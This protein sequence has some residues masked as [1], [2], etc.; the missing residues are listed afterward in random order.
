MRKKG[1]AARIQKA[2]RLYDLPAR[3]EP[4]GAGER[5]ISF[6]HAI[7]PTTQHHG[8]CFPSADDEIIQGRQSHSIDDDNWTVP[9]FFLNIIQ[10]QTI[11]TFIFPSP[12]VVRWDLYHREIVC[13]NI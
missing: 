1:V 6:S 9:A 5:K 12:N 2:R 11:F 10:D 7:L 4:S 13:Y 8:N 3:E